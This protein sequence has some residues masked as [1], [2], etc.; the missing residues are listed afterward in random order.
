MS[1]KIICPS[2]SA[3]SLTKA[4]PLRSPK[5]QQWG[6]SL[7]SPVNPSGPLPKKGQQIQALLDPVKYAPETGI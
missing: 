3:L 6:V 5:A 4:C 2:L 1:N 7:S